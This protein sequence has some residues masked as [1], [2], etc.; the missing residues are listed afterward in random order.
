MTIWNPAAVRTREGLKLN[1]QEIAQIQ[2]KLPKVLNPA[3]AQ[4]EYYAD[5]IFE[6]GGVKGIA[7]LGALR[8]FSEVGIRWRKVAGTSAGAITASLVAADHPIDE[9]ET[10][11]G[12]VDYMND[13]LHK[14]TSWLNLTGSP[15][16]DLQTPLRMLFNLLLTR[17]LGLYSTQP[18][19]DWLKQ[20][21]GTLEKFSNLPAKQQEWYQNRALKVV[22]S[23]VSRGEM[24]VLPDDLDTPIAGHPSR[25]SLA[26]V[27]NLNSPLDFEV[28]EAVRLSMSIPF[29]F[30]PG[31]LAGN[32]IVDGGVL[33]NFP[34]WIFDLEP[35]SSQPKVRPRCPTFGF[36]LVEK[37]PPNRGPIQNALGIFSNMLQTMMVAKDRYNVRVNGQRRIVNI[38]L[39]EPI[40]ATAF[41]LDNATKDKLYQWGYESA[42]DFLLNTWDWNEHLRLRGF[43]PED[44]PAQGG[45]DVKAA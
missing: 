20:N 37:E 38:D 3:T 10:I 43:S 2:A 5:A 16:D 36:R 6:G 32:W 30:E 29:F 28:A 35:I 1:P 41:N 14:R 12:G 21:L 45:A 19:K 27:L 26:Q 31:N 23:D 18:F 34:L 25:A 8:C 15:N 33:S 24:L 44:P 17:K 4:E 9:L 39:K 13:L 22:V 40:S 42:K 11:A 7:F